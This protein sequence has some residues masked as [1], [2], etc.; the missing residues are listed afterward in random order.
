MVI[1]HIIWKPDEPYQLHIY[2]SAKK[3]GVVS[4]FCKLLKDFNGNDG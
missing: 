4:R 3:Q 2:K 1:D